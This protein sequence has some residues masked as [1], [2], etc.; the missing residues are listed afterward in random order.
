MDGQS[1]SDLERLASLHDRGLLT[2]EEFEAAKKR[3]V[4]S[5][6]T[7]ESQPQRSPASGGPD[8]A[9]PVT[10]PPA[11]APVPLHAWWSALGRSGRWL[12]IGIVAA[13][14]LAGTTLVAL[15]NES[16]GTDSE[17]A[18]V[19]YQRVAPAS[20]PAPNLDSITVRR[21]VEQA[22]Q[23]AYAHQDPGEPDCTRVTGG[24]FEC[25]VSRRCCPGADAQWMEITYYPDTGVARVTR[26]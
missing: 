23:A 26:W 9:V 21:V 19:P 20:D 6:A 25:V 1:L 4:D 10:P 2:R 17:G 15:S 13:A 7:G 12:T 3:V 24:V 18:S 5:G 8:D 22:A 11:H 14:V 16:G